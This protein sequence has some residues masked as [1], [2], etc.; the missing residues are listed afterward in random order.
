MA[1]R[2][3]VCERFR[4]S[5]DLQLGRE[6]TNVSFDERAV[7]LCKAHAGIAKNSGVTTLS[8]LRALYA[9]SDGK[10]SFV[11]RRGP[12]SAGAKARFPGRRATDAAT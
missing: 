6:L 4:L 8:E 3:E 2:C 11:S 10:R 1:R 9:E 12:N 5:G 7:L